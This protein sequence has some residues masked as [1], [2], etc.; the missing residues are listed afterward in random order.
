MH[1]ASIS[2]GNSLCEILEMN[3]IYYQ[4]KQNCK[5]ELHSFRLLASQDLLYTLYTFYYFGYSNEGDRA[6]F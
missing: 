1:P 2:W 4:P 3:V 5:L 6:W